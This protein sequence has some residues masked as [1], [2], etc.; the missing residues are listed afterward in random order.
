MIQAEPSKKVYK[1]PREILLQFLML[2]FYQKK[3]GYSKQFPISK[4]RILG[5]FKP[6][7]DT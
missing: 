3:I 6:A 5:L 4:I 2:I 1:L 7:G